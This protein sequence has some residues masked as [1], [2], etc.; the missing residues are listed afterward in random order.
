[1]AVKIKNKRARKNP[2][3]CFN[4]NQSEKLFAGGKVLLKHGVDVGVGSELNVAVDER[5]VC[6]EDND[7]AAGRR[8]DFIN[9]AA[10]VDV[11]D[12]A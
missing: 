4:Q 12:F 6:A 7:I 9:F 8:R 10:D 11:D 2:A 1:M 3:R 5:A